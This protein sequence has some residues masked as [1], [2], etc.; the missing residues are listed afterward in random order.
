MSIKLVNENEI[1]LEEAI[2]CEYDDG[3]KNYC[4]NA[5]W[6][7]LNNHISPV[8]NNSRFHLLFQVAKLILMTSHLNAGMERVYCL[9]NKNKR[10]GAER[11]GLDIEGSLSNILVVKFDRP[12]SK[13]ACYNYRP[14]NS[15]LVSRKKATRLCNKAHCSK[16]K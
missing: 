3:S 9:V 4:F 1:K 14:D 5:I 2:I 8:G 10:Q 12:E 15:L 7:M 6:Y 13:F 16:S 11:N